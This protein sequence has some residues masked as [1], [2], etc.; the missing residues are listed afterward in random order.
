VQVNK[1]RLIQR[2]ADFIINSDTPVPNVDTKV[3]QL[4]IVLNDTVM[5]TFRT[6]TVC[7]L[8]EL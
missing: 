8:A 1:I 2:K 5:F 3:V 7:M 4:V 6:V